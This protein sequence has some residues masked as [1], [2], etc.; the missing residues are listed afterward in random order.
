MPPS[1]IGV[2][3]IQELAERLPDER[4]DQMHA[5]SSADSMAESKPVARPIIAEHPPMRSKRKRARAGSSAHVARARS[6]RELQG[7]SAE[8]CW[9]EP[10]DRRVPSRPASRSRVARRDSWTGWHFRQAN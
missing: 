9:F 7:L 2:V 8:C 10:M 5:G 3:P 6:P 4:T 1:S